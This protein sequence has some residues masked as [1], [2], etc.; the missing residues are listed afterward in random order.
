MDFDAVEVRKAAENGFEQRGT[1]LPEWI[2]YNGHMNVA[3]Y[4]VAF[5]S[6]L[7]F[8]VDTLKYDAE[9]RKR[10]QMTTMT[11][12]GHIQYMG[13]LME[14]QSYRLQNQLYDYDSKRMHIVQ[15][16]Y[17]INEDGSEFLSTSIP[18]SPRGTRCRHRSDHVRH[19]R[20]RQRVPLGDHGMDVAFRFPQNPSLC[21]FP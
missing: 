2:D 6:G 15:T 10:T 14:G 12:E 13:E 16:M 4:L 20:R 9:A 7:D 18:W 8:F 1:V 3:Y 21:P 17:G 19:Q 5:D 11:L